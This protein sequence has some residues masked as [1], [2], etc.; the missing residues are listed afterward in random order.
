MA[1]STVGQA[2]VLALLALA[3]ALRW[4]VHAS[5]PGSRSRSRRWR[6]NP[7]WSAERVRGE[8]LKLGIETLLT[9]IRAPRANAVAER[10]VGTARRAGLDT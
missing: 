4:A 7:G 9:P 5:A 10:L 3:R 6:D 1:G 2:A 8:L